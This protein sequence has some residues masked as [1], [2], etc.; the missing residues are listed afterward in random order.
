MSASEPVGLIAGNGQFP[1]LF[2]QAARDRGVQVVAVAMEGE[3]NPDIREL[4]E[5]CEFVKVGQLG[6]MIKFFQKQSV[7]KAAMAG[8][9]RAQ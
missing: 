4:V 6:K 1:L 8:G 3:T 9:V 5:V 2:A 7:T